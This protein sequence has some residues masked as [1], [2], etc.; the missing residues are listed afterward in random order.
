MVSF[1][2]VKIIYLY[3]LKR[4]LFTNDWREVLSLM[5]NT[6]L[7][8]SKLPSSKFFI[9][10]FTHTSVLPVCYFVG[11]IS[12]PYV[13]SVNVIFPV[14]LGFGFSVNPPTCIISLPGLLTPFF[15]LINF[16]PPTNN[17]EVLH[18]HIPHNQNIFLKM[19]FCYRGN[20]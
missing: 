16:T 2:F 20:K 6:K 8:L 4:S 3:L 19:W 17:R 18:N 11:Y 1:L 7:S 13:L 14:S 10:P 12:M 9:L 15:P 5:S